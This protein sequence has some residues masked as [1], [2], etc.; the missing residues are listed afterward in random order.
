[1]VTIGIFHLKNL[2][3]DHELQRSRKRR[4]MVFYDLQ[5]DKKMADLFQTVFEWSTNEAYTHK[6]TNT[7]AS[8]R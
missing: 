7:R 4:W 1:M 3:Q 2:R 6:H 8:R 5:D